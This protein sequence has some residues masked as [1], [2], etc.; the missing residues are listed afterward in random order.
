RRDEQGS[1][2][3]AVERRSRASQRRDRHHLGLADVGP[4][5]DQSA[6]APPGGRAPH[7]KLG[8]GRR[9]P[10]RLLL[11]LVGLVMVWAVAG[12][13]VAGY[14]VT[15]YDTAVTA[16]L[17]SV[18]EIVALALDDVRHE[19]WL[20]AHDPAVVEGTARRDWAT[21]LHGALPRILTLQ[22]ERLAALPRGPRG[23]LE[24]PRPRRE[25]GRRAGVGLERCPANRPDRDRRRDVARATARRRR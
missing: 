24:R 25:A 9:S 22:Q 6:E 13:V 23:G 17:A 16:S 12:V 20:L 8:L 18:R 19:A 11:V 7:V 5:D 15:R 10:R 3:H 14:V 1:G 2:G 4:R 21:L